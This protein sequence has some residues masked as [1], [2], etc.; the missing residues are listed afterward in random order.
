MADELGLQRGRGAG[1]RAHV[2]A[3]WS[4]HQPD[5]LGQPGEEA[6]TKTEWQRTAPRWRAGFRQTGRQHTGPMIYGC[7]S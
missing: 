3:M 5:R 6:N 1:E 2:S 7:Q 4:R